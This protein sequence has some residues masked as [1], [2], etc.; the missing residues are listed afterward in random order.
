MLFSSF[1]FLEGQYWLHLALACVESSYET[2][3]VCAMN[4][5]YVV[6]FAGLADT[7]PVRIA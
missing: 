4:G 6:W 2:M 5:S 7:R 3:L 1:L